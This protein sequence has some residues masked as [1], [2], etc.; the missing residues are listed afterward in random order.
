MYRDEEDAARWEDADK[1]LGAW[2][3]AFTSDTPNP[4]AKLP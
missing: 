4:S 1:R 3:E 2:R